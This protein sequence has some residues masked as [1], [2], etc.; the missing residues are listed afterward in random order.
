MPRKGETITDPVVL[1]R[2]RVAREKAAEKRREMA[3]QRK[4]LKLAKDLE[5]HHEVEKAKKKI[6]KPEPLE[7]EDYLPEKKELK[8]ES[9]LNV[10]KEEPE[11]E[12][13]KK[14]KSKPKP[15]K[16]IV[17]VSDSEESEPEEI[18]EYR[19]KK[20]P[21]PA[22]PPQQVPTQPQVPPP[23]YNQLLRQRYI[24]SIFG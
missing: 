7:E 4:T 24:Q 3:E 13:R 14:P 6:L 12:V 10:D 23:N 18:V 8:E 22:P 2:L 5:R 11:V 16:K 1:E 19:R 9:N 15:K 20:K 17:Y 21:M